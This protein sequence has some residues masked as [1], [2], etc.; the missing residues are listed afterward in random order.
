[1][2]GSGGACVFAALAMALLLVG[3]TVQAQSFGNRLMGVAERAV[4]GEVERKVDREVR[5][6]TRCALGDEV[7]IEE[8]EARGEQVE[9]VRVG[10]PV[11]VAATPA[12]APVQRQ[13]SVA[14]TPR[15]A[16]VH[17][18]AGALAR[19]LEHSGRVTLG[20][21]Q[22]DSARATLRP[23]SAAALDQVALLLRQQPQLRLFII[24]HTDSS[25]SDAANQ[26]L[27]QQRA[28][29]VRNALVGR[30]VA[31]SRLVPTGVGSSVPVAD[32]ATEWGRSRNRR[33]EL[34]KE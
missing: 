23:G 12:P 3:A 25:G 33:V 21:L 17:A 19:E 13:A 4:K 30:G 22:F 8:A 26:A 10:T 34:V 16:K 2:K 29:S 15:P 20:G 31:P 14:A 18:D 32:N 28:E 9:V 27:S 24:G 5:R 6:V 11:P 1:M 7:C